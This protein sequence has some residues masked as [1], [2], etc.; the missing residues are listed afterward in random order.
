MSPKYLCYGVV[1]AVNCR[2]KLPDIRLTACPPTLYESAFITERI[3]GLPYLGSAAG[4]PTLNKQH[5]A[6]VKVC[7]ATDMC[8]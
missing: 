6:R 5:F 8:L 7:S 3:F 4:T 1:A 2:D